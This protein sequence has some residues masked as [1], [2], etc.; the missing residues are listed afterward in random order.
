MGAIANDCQGLAQAGAQLLILGLAERARELRG[1]ATKRC[2]DVSRIIAHPSH[3]RWQY[4]AKCLRGW[5]CWRGLPRNGLGLACTLLRGPIAHGPCIVRASI[6][7]A[8]RADDAILRSDMGRMGGSV[9]VRQF[10]RPNPRLDLTNGHPRA[11]A[12][13][14]V[15]THARTYAC[16]HARTHAPTHARTHAGLARVV[17]LHVVTNCLLPKEQSSC[18]QE[19][20]SLGSRLEALRLIITRSRLLPKEQSSEHQELCSLGSRP[21]KPTFINEDRRGYYPR[22]KVL[23]V[24]NFVP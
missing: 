1:H 7:C 4:K 24:K 23:G 9:N 22:N 21:F 13:T 5:R 18:D 17:E 19:L 12:R 2:L 10:L 3:M 6:A 16:T 14:Q 15:R 20:C 11:H 8:L